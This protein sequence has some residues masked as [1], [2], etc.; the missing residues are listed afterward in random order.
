MNSEPVLVQYSDHS[1]PLL[2]CT[3]KTHNLPGFKPDL[4][5]EEIAQYGSILKR[6]WLPATFVFLLIA[7]LATIYTV[8]QTPIYQSKGQLLFKKNS[9]TSSLL[10]GLGVGA[11][12]DVGGSNSP[13][14]NQLEII[15]SLPIIEGAI[16]N[17]SLQDK[18]GERMKAEQFLTQMKVAN[19]K[20]TDVLDFSYQDTDATR[21]ARVLQMVFDLYQQKDLENQRKDSQAARIFVEKQLPDLETKV[22]ESESR[23]RDF[24]EKHQ[25]VD[26]TSEASR[27]VETIN[28]LNR[29]ITTA[30][31][32]LAAE[33]SRINEMKKIL[34]DNVQ[35]VVQS[36]LVSESP[37]LRDGIA[38][39]LDARKRLA[40]ERTRF[41]DENASVKDLSTKVAVL[42][43]DL[44][45]RQ[46]ANLAGKNIPGKLTD[47]QPAGLQT[48]M[49]A[50]YT[51]AETQRVA[52]EQ[53]INALVY[54][55]TAYRDRANR[56]PQLEQAQRELNRQLEVSLTTYRTLRAK[57]EEFRIA[58]NQTT[59]NITLVT[60]PTVNPEAISP[61]NVQNIAIGSFLGLFLGA[62]AAFILDSTDRRIKTAQEA[63][64]FFPDYSIL[65]RI[66]DFQQKEMVVTSKLMFGKSTRTAGRLMA[67]NTGSDQENEAFR[68][69]QANLRFL[70]ADTPIKAIV[71]SS[72]LPREGKSTVAANLALVT[73]ELGRK[74]LLVDGDMRKPS[75]HRIWRQNPD[76]GLSNVLTNQSKQEEAII[77]VEP[78]LYLLTAG[79]PPPNPIAL[80]DS[81][82]M[83]ILIS[84]WTKTYDL[85]IIDAPPLTVAADATLLSKKASGIVFVM[86]PNVVD[87]DAAMQSREILE[88][89][90]QNVLGMVLNGIPMESKKY[91]DYYYQGT[92]PAMEDSD[93]STGIKI[94]QDA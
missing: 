73:A 43:A 87:K 91:N 57:L 19:I 53:Q 67:R 4:L 33:K 60:P 17:L 50:D 48:S 6:R 8:K 14:N 1:A 51:R 64:Q 54:V 13:V 46:A 26:L 52:L 56:L 20:S 71:V 11:L 39:L 49:V 93:L 55:S 70:N 84:E 59:G 40:L 45:R 78:N 86:R 15:R 58:E 68:S 27:S 90:E 81:S 74:V 63:Q 25:V 35:S 18:K 22:R 31:A 24:R 42:E 38:A 28:N 92:K 34:G 61:K 12:A 21:A 85:V 32:Q 89:S 77:E 62:A 44:N 3:A 10:D 80:I 7:G 88:Q 30:S 41:T 9:K 16:S 94:K 23:I 69:L 29:E 65:G 83:G 76:V 5:M 37:G 79:T 47:L 66:P 82:Q 2:N 75:Q 72:S 36:A